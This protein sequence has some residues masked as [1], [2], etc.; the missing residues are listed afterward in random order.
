MN[1]IVTGAHGALGKRVISAFASQ[2][3]GV[4]L[5]P[6]GVDLTDPKGISEF[7]RIVLN[8]RP[9]DA[10]VHLAGGYE[11]GSRIED[12]LPTVFANMMKINFNTAVNAFKA[13]LPI[14]V[15]QRSGRIVAIAAEAARVPTATVAAYAASKAALYSLVQTVNAE[16]NGLGIFATALT[17]RV[18]DTDLVRD[19][20]AQEIV[21]FVHETKAHAA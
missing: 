13:V 10:L 1:V 14:M 4:L 12:T 16:N 19:Q 8:A 2:G 15:Q 21:S 3:D 6:A 11:G 7:N 17:P 9:V 5:L 20:I 18:L